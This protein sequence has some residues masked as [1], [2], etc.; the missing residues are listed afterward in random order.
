VSASAAASSPAMSTAAAAGCQHGGSC[1]SFPVLLGSGHRVLL[2]QT[3]LGGFAGGVLAVSGESAL[4]GG[5][6]AYNFGQCRCQIDIVGVEKLSANICECTD[7][8]RRMKALMKDCET[9]RNE[10]N[11]HCCS[12]CAESDYRVHLSQSHGL[13][14]RLHLCSTCRQVFTS[15][16]ELRHH[17]EASLHQPWRSSRSPAMPRQGL[18]AVFHLAEAPGGAPAAAPHSAAAAAAPLRPVSGLCLAAGCNED[19]VT[20]CWRFQLVEH[21]VSVGHLSRV[22]KIHPT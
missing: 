12:L 19:D 2:N 15:L 21:C 14:G 1:G 9:G 6:V 16:A 17:Q 20:F 7:Y 3:L 22:A 18:S 5:E 13:A 10:R 4:P 8:T 11:S